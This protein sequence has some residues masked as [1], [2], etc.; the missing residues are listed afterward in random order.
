MR[1][2]GEPLFETDVPPGSDMVGE[3][4]SGPRA[5]DRMQFELFGHFGVSEVALN[6]LR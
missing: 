1:G 6:A 5:T 3:T 2:T 4:M